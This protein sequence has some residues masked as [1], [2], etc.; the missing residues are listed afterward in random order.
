MKKISILITGLFLINCSS[1]YPTQSFNSDNGKC[2]ENFNFR[3]EYFYH[4]KI[5]DSLVEKQNKQF[6]K[7]LLFVSKYAHVSAESMLNSTGTY[8][9]GVYEDDRKDWIEWYEKNKCNN[10]Q[11]KK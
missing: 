6:T 9:I 7:S 4:I 8:P 10:I 3:K 11:F 5:I 1:I 2:T